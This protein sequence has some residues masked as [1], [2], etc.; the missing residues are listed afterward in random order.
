VRA[1]Y[2]GT[3]FEQIGDETREAFEAR[4]TAAV[5]SN[6]PAGCALAVVFCEAIHE[7]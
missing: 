4:V 7:A 3:A 1:T 5:K 2:A 6:P